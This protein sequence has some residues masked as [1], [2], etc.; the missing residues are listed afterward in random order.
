VKKLLLI[1]IIAFAVAGFI[2]AQDTTD[3][4]G[5]AQGEFILAAAALSGD[6]A[7]Y[8][9]GILAVKPDSLGVPIYAA[10]VVTSRPMSELAAVSADITDWKLRFVEAEVMKA[11]SVKMYFENKLIRTKEDLFTL[12]GA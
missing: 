8:R 7:E 5:P 11:T 1:S 2:F 4:G 6:V 10:P 3:E 12:R 9:A